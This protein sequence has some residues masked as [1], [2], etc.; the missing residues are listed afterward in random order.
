MRKIFI[1]MLC[2]SLFSC[3]SQQEP[4]QNNVPEALQEN[5]TT[6]EI[7]FSKKRAPENLVE[8][9]YEEKLQKTPDL[10]MLEN[11]ISELAGRYGDSTVSFG[12]FKTKNEAYFSNAK[13]FLAGRMP[14]SLLQKEAEALLTKAENDYKNSIAGLSVLENTISGNNISID[15]R[16]N[17]LKLVVSLAMM[18]QY[19]KEN[20]PSPKP[21]QHVIAEQNGLMNNLDKTIAQNK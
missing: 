14:D 2:I 9:L 10:Q 18:K 3:N 11:K 16:H 17:M 19:Q 1:A 4:Q 21:L 13:S 20:L 15:D 6:K 12:L 7:S 8:E 5:N